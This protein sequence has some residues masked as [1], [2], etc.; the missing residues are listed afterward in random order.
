MGLTKTRIRIRIRTEK[1]KTRIRM[2]QDTYLTVVH[3][4]CVPWCKLSG[5][6]TTPVTGAKHAPYCNILPFSVWQGPPKT[7]C[8]CKMTG[9]GMEGSGREGKPIDKNY[10]LFVLHTVTNPNFFTFGGGNE[11]MCSEDLILYS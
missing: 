8:A 5:A 6:R 1:T 11:V 9:E 10:A 3:L 4:F 7:Q 2:L